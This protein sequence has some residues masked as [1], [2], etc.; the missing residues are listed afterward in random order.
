MLGVLLVTQK[1][2][3]DYLPRQKEPGVGPEGFAEDW[4]E[5]FGVTGTTK[6]LVLQ[7]FCSSLLL[8][9]RNS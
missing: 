1:L 4:M 9:G 2:L 5:N 3:N 8:I 6:E 7:S